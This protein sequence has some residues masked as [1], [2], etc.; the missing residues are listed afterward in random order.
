MANGQGT[1]TTPGKD[2]RSANVESQLYHPQDPKP[3]PDEESPP[4]GF[5]N[6]T[7]RTMRAKEPESTELVEAVKPTKTS[8]AAVPKGDIPEPTPRPA[9]GSG[10]RA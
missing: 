10:S 7:T 1:M 6:L 9:W 4:Q 8:W 2:V 3:A 5:F